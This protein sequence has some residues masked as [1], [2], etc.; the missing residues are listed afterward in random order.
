LELPAQPAHRQT[1]LAIEFLV[2]KDPPSLGVGDDDVGVVIP[3]T[4]NLFLIPQHVSVAVLL[5]VKMYD[6]GD[7]RN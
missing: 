2:S 4:V 6:L 1:L 5:L 7:K 3:T